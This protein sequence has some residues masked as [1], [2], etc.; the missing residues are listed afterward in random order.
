MKYPPPPS[1]TASWPKPWVQLKYFTYQPAVYPRFI[2]H[3]SSGAKRGELVTVYDKEGQRFGA[4]FWN[5][6]ARV[7]LRMMSHRTDAFT[8][9]QFPELLN[10]AAT[11]RRD[12]FRLE[13]STDAYRVV[14]SDGDGLS[15]LI[16]DK[17][18]DVLRVETH[19][20]GV[21]TRLPEWLPILHEALGTKRHLISVDREIANIETIP[22]KGL[23][24][25]DGVR[26]V[27]IKENGVRYWVN[28]EE[29]HK[30]GF[31]CD[32]RDNRKRLTAFT[33]GKRVLDLCCY[34]GGFSLSAKVT[35]GAEEVTGVDLDEKAIEQAKQNANLNQARIQ[36]VHTDAF[37]YARQMQ[38]QGRKWDVVILD[39]PKLVFSREDEDGGRRKYED[40]N[41]LAMT[42]VAPGGVLVTCS[43]SGL[44]TTEEFET[45]A[46]KAAH[47][48]KKRL[49]FFDRTVAGP[50]HPVMSN[51]L[52]GSYLKL[53][54]AR[55]W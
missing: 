23:E 14:H 22:Y 42:L 6:G 10:R 27:K 19:S 38:G 18:A 7:P 49:Q 52:E 46:I 21:Y 24:N 39:P 3:V 41:R 1:D 11:M 32:Q 35:G 31:F 30:T 20:H 48:E 37:Q 25:P 8:E 16:V 34:T 50:D 2:A 9:A 28:F 45:I 47:R 43:C 53:L 15:G 51:C 40:L 5:P 17:Y 55:V 44:L 4:G 36:W 12:V 54:W 26:S 33:A 29:G 13:E